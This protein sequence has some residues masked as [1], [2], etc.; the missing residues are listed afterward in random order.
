MKRKHIQ[1]VRRAAILLVMAFMANRPAVAAEYDVAAFFW[2]AYH[3]SE[4]WNEIAGWKDNIGEWEIVKN[5]KPRFEGHEQPNVPIWGYQDESDPRAMEKKIDAA[6]DHGVNVFIFDW[7]WY[8]NKPFQEDALNKGFLKAKNNDRMKFYLMWANHDAGSLWNI[9]KSHLGNKVVWPGAVDRPTFDI[10]VDRVIERYMKQPT[11][12][13][14]D[15]KPVFSIYELGTLIKGLGGV[16]QT[17]AALDSFRAKVKAA[18]FP[19]L[20]VQA[21]LWSNIPASAALVPGDRSNTQANTL[22][23]LGF[24]SLTNYQWVH[25]VHANG[26]YKGWGKKALT[27]WE[28]WAKEFK[29]PFYPHVSIGW[30]TNPRYKK[31]QKNTIVNR[32]PKEFAEF[33]RQA[34]SHVDKHKL[35]PRLITINSWN[36]WCEGSYLEPCERY[37][38][39]FLEAVKTVFIDEVEAD[40]R[41]AAK[42]AP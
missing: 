31:F 3:P 10:V 41:A 18:G 2:P 32:S 20:H 27:K 14:I 26:D 39:G 8:D 28:P 7:Y 36:E 6:A 12:Y 9:E 24:D 17:K 4:R 37:G 35:Q 13:K 1:W 38:M 42:P 30:D 25:Y 34:K 21:I 5:C 33:L 23:V 40:R 11:Y 29:V 16:E 19:G 15:G 22:E